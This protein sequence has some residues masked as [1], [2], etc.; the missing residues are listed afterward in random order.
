MSEPKRDKAWFWNQLKELGWKPPATKA[1][2][3]YKQDELELEYNTFQAARL[4]NDEP[5]A[6]DEFVAP[7]EPPVHQP[8]P[9]FD[10]VDPE[11][12]AEDT[13]E[14]NAVFHE[15]F[16][17]AYPADESE[18]PDFASVFELHEPAE[19]VF[20]EADTLNPVQLALQQ[21]QAAAQAAYQPQDEQAAPPSF[22]EMYP[23]LPVTDVGDKVAGLRQNTH[24]IDQP[25]RIDSLGRLWF[26]DEVRKLSTAQPRGRRVHHVRERGVKT[27]NVRN[28]LGL[29][30]ESFEVAGDI[31]KDMQVK[32]TLPV[33]QVGI[34]ADP[35]FP[36]RIHVYNDV[37]GFDRRDIAIFYGGSKLV[38]SRIE[39][40]YIGGDLCYDITS[41]KDAMEAE[42]RE[43]VLQIGSQFS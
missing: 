39:T 22:R 38:P 4:I 9:M 10:E 26:Q 15:L 27:I 19:P 16:P 18:Q 23:D 21:A 25:I 7:F 34:Y 40:I 32:T 14:T 2:V 24:T 31:I 6:D 5:D 13:A 35:R 3:Q 20:T 41:V 29:T 42:Y 30:D 12:T 37:E 36:F 17:D 8:D 43:R 33:S 28:E 11:Y 1:F